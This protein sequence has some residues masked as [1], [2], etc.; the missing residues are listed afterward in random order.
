MKRVPALDGLRG[1]AIL[2]VVAGHAAANYQPM[3][4]GLRRWLVVFSNSGLGVRLFFVLSGYLITSLLLQ[5]HAKRGTISLRAF[6]LRRVLRIFPA[7]YTF[8]F[9]LTVLSL[10]IPS[11]LTPSTWIASATFTWNY[12][13]A[14][15]TSP[16]EGTWNLGHFWTLALEEQFYLLWPLTLRLAGIRR[17]LYIAIALVV[18]C[19]LARLGTYFLFPAERGY[20]VMM[21]HT[22]SDSIMVGCAAAL[23][24]QSASVREKFT[25][26][27]STGA[28]VAVCWMFVLSPLLGELI[29]GFPVVAGITVDALASAWIILWA[30]QILPT[31]FGKLLGRGLLP[32]LGT[33]SYSLYLWQ[34]IFLSPTGWL[35]TGRWLSACGAAVA[36]ACLSYWL[37]EKPALRLK[38][39]RGAPPR[40]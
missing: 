29:R 10:W 11:G 17:A 37:I 4:E 35:A 24:M 1:I 20:I 27:A 6:Y 28:W 22:G 30:R 39:R 7:F 38:N 40:A 31:G 21:F 5:E 15:V 14:W 3:D 33:I 32:A 12:A 26:V 36:V 19:P 9:T 23:L 34:Q 13:H 18:W 16:P 8:L 25:R 2:M